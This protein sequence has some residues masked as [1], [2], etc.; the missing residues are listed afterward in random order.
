[1][2]YYEPGLHLAR[3]SKQGWTESKTKKAMLVFEVAIL[4]KVVPDQEGNESYED[5]A[6]SQYDQTLRIVVD[7][8]SPDSL[9]YAMRKLRYAG[10]DGDSFAD[11]NLEGREVRVRNDPQEYK[12]KLCDSWDFALPPRESTAAPLDNSAARKFDALF[13]RRLKDGAQPKAAKPEPEAAPPRGA[14]TPNDEVPF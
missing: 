13:G 4:A 6:P 14:A 8:D 2:A 3:V 12:G 1:M 5:L 7:S 10:F 9:D 11:L